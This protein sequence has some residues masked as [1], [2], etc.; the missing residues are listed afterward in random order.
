MEVSI[1]QIGEDFT[2]EQTKKHDVIETCL[3]EYFSQRTIC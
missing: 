1:E 2:I 3:N